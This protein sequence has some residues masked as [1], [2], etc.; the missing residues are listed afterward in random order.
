MMTWCRACHESTV[1]HCSAHVPTTTVPVG[2]GTSFVEVVPGARTM[3]EETTVEPLTD[4]ELA[5]LRAFI[6]ARTPIDQTEVGEGNPCNCGYRDL[7]ALL[8]GPWKG[9][10]E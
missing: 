10:G 1:G 4:E 3:S 2:D 8:D 7:R 6:A 9:I 5:E